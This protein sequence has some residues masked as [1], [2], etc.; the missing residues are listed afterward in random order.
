MA[1]KQN[2]NA[3]KAHYESI[4][5][6]YSA[7]YYDATSMQYRKRYFFDYLLQGISLEGKRV[8]EL[9]CGTGANSLELHERFP[10]V[11]TVGFDISER[12][13]ADYAENLQSEA[14]QVDLTR[15][16]EPGETFD[17]A[18]VIGGLH[19]CVSDM[20]MTLNNIARMLKPGGLLLMMEPNKNFLLN[21]VRDFW[22][23]TDDF[24]EAGT[25]AALD[26]EELVRL[27]QPHFSPL[28]VQYFGGPAF[29][30]I[31]NSM[32]TR[33]PLKA[34]PALS[35]V[36]FPLETLYNKLPGRGP[37]ASFLAVWERR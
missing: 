10:S 4:H 37:F 20:Q 9:A 8:A 24:F 11:K 22:Y 13:C 12:A 6:A 18:M 34:K 7:H 29:Y 35:K 2:D 23:K 3:Q 14:Y 1:M 21:S 28:R 27:G 5:D 32:I 30:L 19:H 31:F 17:A 16:Y 15:E 26:H 33:V 25:E 36:L